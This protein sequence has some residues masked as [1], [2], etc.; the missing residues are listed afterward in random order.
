MRPIE[1]KQPG[2]IVRYIDSNN[3]EIE[4]TILDD[5]MNYPDSKFVLVANLDLYCS[6][7]EGKEKIHSLEVEHTA[8]KSKGGSLT[9]WKNFLLCCKICNTV[10][11]AEVVNDEYHW[12]HINNTFYSFIY[13]DTGRIHVND[14]IPP[15]SKARA[16]KLLDLTG[17]QRYPGTD[18]TPSSKDFRW[19]FRY[20]AWNIA[21]RYKDLFSK[22]CV[23]EDDII[24][25]AKS[26]GQWSI[27][28]TVFKGV[29]SVRSRL[30]SDFPGTCAACFDPNNH[31]EPIERNPGH[32][33]PV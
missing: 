10:K 7:C 16:Q 15:L 26:M 18:I 33:D 29:D 21:S 17:L 2:D 8:A 1:K 32:P 19:K 23:T 12:P 25:L 3:R 20:E 28:F 22:G 11:G 30:I 4:H 9:A 27:W 31:Y 5:Y 13:D 24:G 6:Y 14:D